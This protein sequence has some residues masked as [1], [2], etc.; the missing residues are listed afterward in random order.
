VGNLHSQLPW[1]LHFISHEA[2]CRLS[3]YPDDDNHDNL[4]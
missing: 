2:P 4:V 1:M 3:Q